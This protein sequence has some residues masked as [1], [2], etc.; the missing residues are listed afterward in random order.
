MITLQNIILVLA[1][2]GFFYL[3]F[4]V[5]RWVLQ[6]GKKPQDP[7]QRDPHRMILTPL[8]CFALS[9]FS[10]V[11]SGPISHTLM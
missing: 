6:D 4:I 9:G 3:A 7:G 8:L 5:I 1:V 2:L 11:P 10:V